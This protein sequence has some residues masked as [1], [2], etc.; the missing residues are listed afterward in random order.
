MS[1]TQIMDQY[2]RRAIDAELNGWGAWLERNADY[3][4]YPRYD[5]IQAFLNGAGGGTA[6]HRVLCLDMPVHVYAVH[7][8][9]LRLPEAEMEAVY[10]YFAFRLKPD[11]ETFW[12][13]EDKCKVAGIEIESMRR[14]LSRARYRIAGI[15]M[16]ERK[17]RKQALATVSVFG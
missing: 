7:A 11:G 4:G 12:T 1:V 17:E 9:V 3:Q 6:G 15:P 16:A 13:I 14:R 5:N 8:R 2:T 10:L